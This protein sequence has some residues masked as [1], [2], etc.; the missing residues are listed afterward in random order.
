MIQSRNWGLEVKGKFIDLGTHLCYWLFDVFYHSMDQYKVGLG[1]LGLNGAPKPNAE[2]NI[3][4]VHIEGNS[5]LLSDEPFFGTGQVTGM[6]QPKG[7]L[8]SNINKHVD[9]F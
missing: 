9:E 2:E 6:T 1:L 5:N 3:C 8:S 7:L 4:T